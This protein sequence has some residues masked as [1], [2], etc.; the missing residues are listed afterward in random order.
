MRMQYKITPSL[1]YSA[2]YYMNGTN[3]SKE[4]LLSSLLG[5]R[6]APSD[7]MKR[8]IRFEKM[9]YTLLKKN[10]DCITKKGIE[11][12][13]PAAVLAADR[14]LGQAGGLEPLVQHKVRHCFNYKGFDILT[15][16][17][18]DVLLPDVIID[19]KRPTKAPEDGKY[20]DSIQHWCYMAATGILKFEYLSGLKKNIYTEKYTAKDVEECERAIGE[21]FVDIFLP[22]IKQDAELFDAYIKSWTFSDKNVNCI[23]DCLTSRQLQ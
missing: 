15:S 18:I 23:E 8:G 16:G 22:C 14:V 7:I 2:Y 4:E 19:I 20:K 10:V 13:C 1:Y 21:A 9:I 17:V 5:I 12:E 11:Q 6:R 3:S